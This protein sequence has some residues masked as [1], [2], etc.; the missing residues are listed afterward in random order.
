MKYLNIFLIVLIGISMS[1]CQEKLLAVLE[2]KYEAL[3]E[4][5]EYVSV[6][7]VPVAKKMRFLELSEEVMPEGA[8]LKQIA[9]IRHGE[10]D[11]NKI[12]RFNYKEA[13]Q[14]IKD[15][16][17]VGILIPDE[18]FFEL[19]EEEEVLIFVSNLNRAIST[20]KYLFGTERDITQSAEFR[21]FERSLGDRRIKM[22]LPLRYW[23][24]TA[25]IEWLLGFNEEGIESFEE[26]RERAMAGA[27]KLATHSERHDKVVLVAHGFLNRYIKKYLKD[28]GWEVVR[29]GGRDYL[30]A[31]ILAKIDEEEGGSIAQMD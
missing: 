21:E 1:G 4:Q 31:T 9:L 29:D 7:G 26:A 19:E 18:P 8:E 23:T 17:S 12:G 6:E 13:K 25:R 14:Y 30:G 20:A 15:Y 5:A 11:L 28:L 2:E 27:I 10:P 16:D 24:I 3:N 22:D